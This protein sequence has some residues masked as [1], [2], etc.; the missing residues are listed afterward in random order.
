MYNTDLPTRAELPSSRQLLIS[1]LAA[2]AIAGVLLVTA[3]LP[4][5]YGVDPTGAGRALGLTQV[6]EIKVALAQE[7][8]GEAATSTPVS[9]PQVASSAIA[10]EPD[11]VGSEAP[12]APVVA[13]VPVMDHTPV[14]PKP[15]VVMP[16]QRDQRVIL[17]A[18]G[19]AAEL[20]LAM[21]EGDRVSYRWTTEGGT[22]NFDTHGDNPSTDYHGYD[23]GRNVGGDAGELVAAFDGHHG[24][25]WRNRSGAPVTL[26]LTT[27]GEYQ[28][29]KR[30]L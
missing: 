19:A 3:I 4:A 20:K 18:P 11:S 21:R 2:A 7:A 6:G 30:V 16:L 27:E 24:W 13:A 10:E 25:F 9:A 5:E 14:S 28:A 29:I 1:T 23:K 17:L 12:A 26:T 22:L 8:A 15:V